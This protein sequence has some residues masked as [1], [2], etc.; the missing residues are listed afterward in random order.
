M[1]LPSPAASAAG[2]AARN[3]A[4]ISRCLRRFPG[5]RRFVRLSSRCLP[6]IERLFDVRPSPAFP[7]YT[8]A[9]P[10]WFKA[11]A[12]R[13]SR[14][15]AGSR[16]DQGTHASQHR[17]SSRGSVPHVR[18][19]AM[20][21][22]PTLRRSRVC[23]GPQRKGRW[24]LHE[25]LLA[26]QL[27]MPIQSFE[28]LVCRRIRDT[29]ANGTARAFTALRGFGGSRSSCRRRLPGGRCCGEPG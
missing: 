29:S 27:V 14:C 7:R 11:G 23:S 25:T 21:R 4:A 8:R 18:H 1:P 17:A 5:P 26:P 16:C 12:S 6:N 13:W 3:S 20:G 10:F 9:A 2:F 15:G 22:H 19:A 28:T 24:T